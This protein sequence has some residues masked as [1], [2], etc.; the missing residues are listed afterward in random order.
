MDFQTYGA[1]KKL[2]DEM[3]PSGSSTAADVSYDNTGSKLTAA[4]VQ[5][6]IDAVNSNLLNFKSNLKIPSITIGGE[7]IAAYADNASQ[8][9]FLHAATSTSSLTDKPY[10]GAILYVIINYSATN[11]IILAFPTAAESFYFVKRKYGSTS[12]WTKWYK[13]SGEIQSV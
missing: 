10:N 11:K 6:A 9:L 5:A 3:E 13:Y 1:L 12:P 8:G 4:N 2:I 7:K